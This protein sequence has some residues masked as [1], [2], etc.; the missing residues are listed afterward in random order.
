[1]N[2]VP[3]TWRGGI[4]AAIAILVCIGSTRV[5]F[6]ELT[7][8]TDLPIE[9]TKT[10]E[11]DGKYLVYTKTTTFEVTDSYYPLCWRFNSS[12]VWGQ[13]SPGKYLVDTRG[14]RWGWMSWY[15]NI[16][17]LVQK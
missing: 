8:N 4:F 10:F 14:I 16:C 17:K 7:A 3:K 13:V 6:L 5:W 11:K 15:P 9:V 12:D 1:M 2:M